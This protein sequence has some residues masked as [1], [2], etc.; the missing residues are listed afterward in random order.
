MSTHSG[1][2]ASCEKF[3]GNR[4]QVRTER[5][6]S[7]L[8]VGCKYAVTGYAR[9][10]LTAGIVEEIILT[11]TSENEFAME[12]DVITT[13]DN[14]SWRGK[15]DIDTN[16]ITSLEDNR[17]NRVYGAVGTEVD[18]FPWTDTG[19]REN[20]VDNA[21]VLIDCD[22]GIT[23]TNNRF[24]SDSS[25]DLRG[26]TGFM[27]NS[28][29]G[30]D[31]QLTLT[32]RTNVR[33]TGSEFGSRSR[34]TG[35]GGDNLYLYY[36]THKSEAYWIFNN[37]SDVRSYYST[38]NSTARVYGNA[39]GLTR[40]WFYYTNIGSYGHVRILSGTLQMYYSKIDSYAEYRQEAGAGTALIYGADW[41]A[42]GYIRNYNTGQW[43]SYYD[44]LSS[45]GR[46]TI[47]GTVNL[48]S[49]YNNINSYGRV[50]LTDVTV[51]YAHLISSF[52]IWTSTGANH[53][54]STLDSYARLTTGAF[55]TRS[56]YGKGSWAQTLTAANTNK[57][58]DYFNNNLV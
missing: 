37:N 19:V 51:F 18:R 34:I 6:Q 36:H 56:V 48:A 45:T 47:N 27:T 23:L 26:T 54:R 22:T 16:R 49:Y 24:D 25:T 41:S 53:Y 7:R 38:F 32:N 40:Q 17:G 42:R 1:E 50:I 15:Y 20:I 28:T 3:I 43:R 13:I 10:C 11:A 21:D 33:I 44:T 2:N 5:N 29:V 14:T 30:S 31:A 4:N 52:S 12:V 57:G 55:L 9:G 35:S 46:L 8:E 39:G 58:R